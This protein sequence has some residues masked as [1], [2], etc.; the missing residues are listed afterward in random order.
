MIDPDTTMSRE[1][2]AEFLAAL[3]KLRDGMDSFNC[4]VVTL[5]STG[6]RLAA[7]CEKAANVAPVGAGT[8][9]GGLTGVATSLRSFSITIGEALPAFLAAADGV[10]R[11]MR[12]L[13]I[14]KRKWTH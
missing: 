13:E 14:E 5:N 2:G 1:E 12:V 4:Q 3:R 10:A 6:L 11:G 8:L 7:L 9:V